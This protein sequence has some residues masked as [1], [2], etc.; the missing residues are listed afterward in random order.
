MQRERPIAIATALVE[1][2][3]LRVLF[4]TF[5]P[6]KGGPDPKTHHRRLMIERPA[7]FDPR[8]FNVCSPHLFPPAPSDHVAA[9]RCC[10]ASTLQRIRIPDRA[11]R[12]PIALRIVPA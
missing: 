11:F 4:T 5:L 7:R 9:R 8:Q 12:R 6:V 3:H 1:I 2:F 10:S